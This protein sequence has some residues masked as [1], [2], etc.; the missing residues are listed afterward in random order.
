MK[1]NNKNTRDRNNDKYH[2]RL[3][4]QENEKITDNL[5][6]EISGEVGTNLEP[7]T[8]RRQTGSIDSGITKRLVEQAGQQI[9]DLSINQ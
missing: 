4:V 5:N 3:V 2:D 9:R 6:T 7:E 1:N 8:A